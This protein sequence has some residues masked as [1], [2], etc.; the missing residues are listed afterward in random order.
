MLID[1]LVAQELA[2]MHSLRDEFEHS[3]QRNYYLSV[4]SAVFTIGVTAAIAVIAQMSFAGSAYLIS[5]AA[6]LVVVLNSVD[7]VFGCK[8]RAS[9]HL[10]AHQQLE[11]LEDDLRY[12][13]EDT[14]GSPDADHKIRLLLKGYARRKHA[15]CQ[16]CLRVSQPSGWPSRAKSST[17]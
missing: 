2:S 3:Y 13:I 9:R 1:D 5:G 15:I 12:S 6:A 16:R 8:E 17:S 7:Q 10:R 14:A 4:G 11:E